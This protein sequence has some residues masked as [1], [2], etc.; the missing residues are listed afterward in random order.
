MAPDFYHNADNPKLD[1]ADTADALAAYI[2]N[3]GAQPAGE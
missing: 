2:A 3:I 1:D